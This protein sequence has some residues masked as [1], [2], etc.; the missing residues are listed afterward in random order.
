MNAKKN[1]KMEDKKNNLIKQT[2][3][4]SIPFLSRLHFSII[5]SSLELRRSLF[6]IIS[7]QQKQ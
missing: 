5:L 1:G 6:D 4:S 7:E 2:K 3:T